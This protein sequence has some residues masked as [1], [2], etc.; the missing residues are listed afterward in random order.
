MVWEEEMRPTLVLGLDRSYLSFCLNRT[1]TACWQGKAGAPSLPQVRL[2]VLVPPLASV[3]TPG[4]GVPPYFRALVGVQAPHWPPL[5]ALIVSSSG[6]V[7][8]TQPTFLSP[9]WTLH[10]R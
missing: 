4:A 10:I 1:L 5:T 2:D 8:P 7:I 6:P 3:H 9:L